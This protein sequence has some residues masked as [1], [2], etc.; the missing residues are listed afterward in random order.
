MPLPQIIHPLRF[1]S[2]CFA[3][4]YVQ[5]ENRAASE[6]NGAPAPII[7]IPSSG[8]LGSG[9]NNSNRQPVLQVPAG[10]S[11]SANSQAFQAGAE[12]A[13]A[14]QA[15]MYRGQQAQAQAQAQAGMVMGPQGMMPPVPYMHAA[16]A[17][18]G[19]NGPQDA[20]QYYM[21]QPVYLDQ[22][23]NPVYYRVGKL[24]SLPSVCADTRSY[25]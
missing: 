11:L 21:Q 8:G 22:N 10:S 2:L 7:P 17:G 23:G 9:R 18:G 25:S 20:H 24:S 1:A 4:S 15:Q 12:Q 14:Q 6:A 13:Q 19:P 5:D 16:A 3:Y